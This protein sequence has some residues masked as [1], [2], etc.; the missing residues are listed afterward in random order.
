MKNLPVSL[1]GDMRNPLN[2]VVLTPGGS[3]FQ[4]GKTPDYRQHF[5]GSV[6]FA[7]GS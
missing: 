3:G 6:S 2:F 1:S 5:S 4:P 7:N